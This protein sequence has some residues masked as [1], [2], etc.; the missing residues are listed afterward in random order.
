MRKISID[1]H[2]REFPYSSYEGTIVL[3]EGD[4]PNR[5]HAKFHNGVLQITLPTSAAMT[6]KHIE[7][8]AG[9]L[10]LT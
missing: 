6:P 4:D 5:V 8:E 1:H 9:T 2:F 7:M 3:P 10:A